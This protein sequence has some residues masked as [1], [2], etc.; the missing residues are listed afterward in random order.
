MPDFVDKEDGRLQNS[1]DNFII[2]FVTTGKGYTQ[3][4][5][6]QFTQTTSFVDSPENQVDVL[7]GLEVPPERS[8]PIAYQMILREDQEGPDN[9]LNFVET[10]C[11]SGTIIGDSGGDVILA[12]SFSVNGLGPPNNS[13]PPKE[14]RVRIP[15]LDLLNK[16]IKVA[17]ASFQVKYKG[18]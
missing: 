18:N 9:V 17:I 15:I 5:G 16:T 13:Q 4:D 7:I 1:G 12:T 14:Y 6:I 2:D 3:G 10:K 11:F 8:L